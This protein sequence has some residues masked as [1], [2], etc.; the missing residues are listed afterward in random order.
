MASIGAVVISRND[1]Y[2]GDLDRKFLYGLTSMIVHLD[3]VYYVDWNSPNDVPLIELVRDELPK[4]NKLHVIVVTQEQAREFT[5]N[6]PDVQACVEVMARNIGIRRL[7]TDWI[8]STNSDIMCLSKDNI[9]RHLSN[10]RTF[11]C[12]ARSEVDFSEV[13]KFVPGSQEI[14]DY[15]APRSWPQH[16]DGSPLGPRDRWSL[17]SCPGDFQIAHRNLWYAIKGFD[18]DLVYRGY[19]DS[20]IQ[21]K[22]DYYGFGLVLK[23]D[24]KAYHFK[25]YPNHGASGGHFGGFNDPEKALFNYQ[26]TSNTDNWGFADFKFNEEIL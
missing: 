6:N 4:T 10:E 26:G 23:R 17:I 3:E 9:E 16:P 2:S 24:I 5:N 21:R 15:F 19:G 22:A 13:T 25:H 1:N 11:H 12:V 18:E 7:S 8:I 14:V 20:N